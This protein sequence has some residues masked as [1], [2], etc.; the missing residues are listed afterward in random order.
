MSSDKMLNADDIVNA[1]IELKDIRNWTNYKIA[2]ESDLP[3]S[4]IS[5]IF[6]KK[7]MPQLDTLFALCKGFGITPAQLFGRNEKYEKLT[8]KEA[9]I[10]KQ[11][12]SLDPK[13]QKALENLIELLNSKEYYIDI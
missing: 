5:N 1:L 10:I 11:W 8:D 9:E 7:S 6:N 3:T 2:V 13:S 4:T 12:E